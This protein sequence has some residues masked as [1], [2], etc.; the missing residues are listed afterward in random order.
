MHV[1]G[2]VPPRGVC[3]FPCCRGLAGVEFIKGT[4]FFS[5]LS[6]RDHNVTNSV[7]ERTDNGIFER[8]VPGTRTLCEIPDG[9]VVASSSA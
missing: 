7:C 8:S 4:C 6:V 9:L 2:W 3:L 5:S 1:S